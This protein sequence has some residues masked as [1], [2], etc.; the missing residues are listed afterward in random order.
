[1]ITTLIFVQI[2]IDTDWLMGENGESPVHSLLN[3]KK[4]EMDTTQL[5][6]H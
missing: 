1:M 6:H 3:S 4:T 2:E 5:S